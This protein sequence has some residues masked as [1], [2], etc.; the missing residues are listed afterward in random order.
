MGVNMTTTMTDWER[1]IK[2]HKYNALHNAAKSMEASGG[3][4]AAA[5][6]AAWYV[7]SHDNMTRLETAF[8]DIFFKHMSEYDRSYFGDKI[9]W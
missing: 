4:F 9:H 2:E 8:P 7:A 6:A 1:T 3:H 5:I